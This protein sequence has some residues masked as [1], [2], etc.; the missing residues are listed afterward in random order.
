[1]HWLWQLLDAPAQGWTELGLSFGH[2]ISRDGL[3]TKEYPMRTLN[4]RDGLDRNEQP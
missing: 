3:D 2:R 1:M 4:S